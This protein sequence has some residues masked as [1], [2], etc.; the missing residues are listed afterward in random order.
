[1]LPGSD[2]VVLIETLHAALLD[3][4]RL[5]AGRG[6]SEDDALGFAFMHNAKLG[7]GLWFTSEVKARLGGANAAQYRGGANAAEYR[8]GLRGTD[9]LEIDALLAMYF[10]SAYREIGEEE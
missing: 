10:L 8:G 7:L 6:F 2:H 5:L 9:V 3:L 4:S 1:V